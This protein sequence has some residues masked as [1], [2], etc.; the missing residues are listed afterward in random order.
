MV[1]SWMQ[2]PAKHVFFAG[3]PEQFDECLVAQGHQPLGVY[4][5]KA[6]ACRVQQATG[7]CLAFQPFDFGQASLVNVLSDQYPVQQPAVAVVNGRAA[8]LEPA[9]AAVRRQ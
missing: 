9:L 2:L 1:D 3:K 5:I 4:G 6:F 8:A 7:E